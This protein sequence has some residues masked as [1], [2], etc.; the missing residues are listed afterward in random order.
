MASEKKPVTFGELVGQCLVVL[1][2]AVGIRVGVALVCQP[3][4][5]PAP[6]VHTPLKG[7]PKER[8]IDYASF[9]Q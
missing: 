8:K 5:P 9:L 2:V 3:A 6:P 1:A 4:L 7:E